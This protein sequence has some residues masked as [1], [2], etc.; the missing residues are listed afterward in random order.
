LAPVA[1]AH[2]FSDP[3]AYE[4]PVDV[5][6]GAGRWFTGSSADGFACNACHTGKAG[7]SLVVS[8]L[9]V[10][11]YVPGNAYEIT[12][13]WPPYVMDV[14]LVAEFTTEDRR[15]AGTL[16]LPRPDALKPAELCAA[17]EGGE[18][19]AAIHEVEPARQLVSIVD[20]GAKMLR[21][22][23]TAP[24]TAA[25]PVWFNAGFVTSNQDASPAGDGVTLIARPLPPAGASLPTDM[26]AQGCALVTRAERS[27]SHSYLAVAV[28]VLAI[29][30]T[31]R[32][33]LQR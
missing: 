7:E 29:W 9:P 4:D 21:F 32:R 31:R 26:V 24:L 11:G 14:A 18:S 2:A 16:A 15:G 10:E 19:P 6:G 13:T 5:G 30:R 23:W 28:A 27:P 17:D 3:A 12:L 33:R 22:Q 20:C 25:N 1:S 8:G